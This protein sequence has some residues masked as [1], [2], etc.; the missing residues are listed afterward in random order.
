MAGCDFA[1]SSRSG[2]DL[3]NVAL[4]PGRNLIAPQWDDLTLVTGSG[5]LNNGIYT[6]VM[7]TAPNRVLVIQWLGSYFGSS[8]NS[9]QITF[10]IK[11]HETTNEIE[12][13]LQ[14]LT[15][16][17]DTQNNGASATVG[18]AG[19]TGTTV[20]QLYFN[21]VIS[22]IPQARSFKPYTSVPPSN[23]TA[24]TCGSG[25]IDIRNPANLIAGTQGDELTANVTLPFKFNFYGQC[26]TSGV[27]STN[28]FLRFSPSSRSGA[29][30]SNAALTAGMN[31]IAPLWDDLNSATSL[32]EP[33]NGIYAQTNGVAPN[34]QYIL[35][36]VT[37]Y[38][39]SSNNSDS[40]LF[41][42]ILFEQTNEIRIL[43]QDVTDGTDTQNG[44]SSATVGI[45]GPSGTS[46]VQ[47]SLNT[48]FSAPTCF[49]YIIPCATPTDIT[50]PANVG[51]VQ[52]GTLNPLTTLSGNL[53]SSDP[54][55]IRPANASC[56]LDSI[57]RPYYDV[58]P[59]VVLKPGTFTLSLN[60]GGMDFFALIY[61]GQFNACNPC[62]SLVYWDDDTDS[63]GATP[64]LDPTITFTASGLKTYYLV[65]TSYCSG[66][67]GA[68]TWTI[69]SSGGGKIIDGSF[70]IANATATHC[71]DYCIAYN[72]AYLI[73]CPGDFK[74]DRKFLLTD[75]CLGTVVDSCTQSI[76]IDDTTPPVLICPGDMVVSCP[77]TLP[78]LPATY[79]EFLAA[80]GSA[81]DECCL[82]TSTFRLIG[83][84]PNP[85]TCSQPSI[86]SYEI[87]DTC[88]NA[89]TCMFN[90]VVNDIT[91]PTA[92]CKDITVNL[93]PMGMGMFMASQLDN[94]SSDDCPGGLIFSMDHSGNVTYADT[95]AKIPVTLTVM[96]SCG[97]SATCISLVCVR[98]S[99][100]LE[101]I[102][103]NI[104]VY[105]DAMGMVSFTA[106]DI[107]GGCTPS[108]DCGGFDL[109]LLH[110]GTMTC[111]SLG[112][113][114]VDLE[115]FDDCSADT[116]T[117]LVTVL[118]TIKPMITCPASLTVSC[119]SMVPAQDTNS[120]VATDNCPGVRRSFV[121]DQISSQTCQNRYTLTRTYMA[122]DR[123]GNTATCSQTIT[124]NDI[125]VPVLATCPA[126]VTIQCVIDTGIPPIV[127]FT[128]NC[129]MGTRNAIFGSRRTVG[130][131]RDSLTLFRTWTARDTCGNVASCTQKITI[132]DNVRPSMNCPAPI[133][134]TCASSVPPP[135]TGSVV[136]ADAC[137]NSGIVVVHLK[138]STVNMTCP[139]KFTVYRF[140]RATDACGNT[141]SCSQII[142]VNDNVNPTALCKNITLNLDP[143]GNASITASQINNGSTD[144][145]SSQ[146]NLRLAASPSVFT[147]ANSGP[148]NVTLSVTDECG[149]VGTCVA[150][151]TVSDVTPPVFV[152]S[153]PT[154]TITLNAGPG[155]CEVSWD[156]PPFMA[157]DNCPAG[158]FF[159]SIN[160]V[161]NICRTNAAWQ[162]SGGAGA[163]G[164]LFD[165]VNT[166]GGQLNLQE[167][168]WFSFANEPQYLLSDSTRPICNLRQATASAWTLCASR[169]ATH[170]GFSGPKDTFNLITGTAY[171]TLK[172]CDPIIVDSTKI[173]C[174]TMAAG[175]TRGV[176]IHAPGQASAYLSI[177]G[178]CTTGIFGDAN[179]NTPVNGATYTG[180]L[181]TAPFVNSSFGFGN[182]NWIG[183]IGYALATSNRV[184][185]IQTCGAPYGP[186]CFFPIG[187]TTLCYEARDAG[188]NLATCTFDVCVNAYANPKRS[189]SCND[190][191]QVSL[192]EEC[193]A[194]VGADDVLEGGPYSCYDEYIVE[195][196]NWNT[197]Q[198]IDRRPTVPESR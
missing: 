39:G 80:G 1:G 13:L 67:T 131:C 66:M 146:A 162:I 33:S 130:T 127:T 77:G 14:D 171:D 68:Y 122:T 4:T 117:A 61:N 90:I 92:R 89:D 40:L 72:D 64:N 71:Y 46:F 145:C 187:C 23:Y 178:D 185:V 12:I 48:A 135:N 118:D 105:L 150:I 193:Y 196:R 47:T 174:L 112:V 179:V 56:I 176:Y 55:F 121:S 93:D 53:I 51:P 10:E 164:V 5:E 2:T 63:T 186:G 129:Q 9:D 144:N 85:P 100:F 116:C 188:G 159:G 96:D 99:G 108:S 166:S 25:F 147:C 195:I 91:P 170:A 113:R 31:L 37:S 189:L 190:D 49:S 152:P 109:R 107:D 76:N 36:W 27:V 151:V 57:N 3:S 160:R 157:M 6:Q 42:I 95:L 123:S 192:D 158:Q 184:R 87:K 197:G 194:T 52:C 169:V 173:G 168:G 153:C 78:A 128:D 198:L 22:P 124:V 60:S 143:S 34:R 139:N 183:H 19:P 156:A 70:G 142:T 50:C 79:E 7:G 111:D 133:T 44:G 102:C 126:D 81:T 84:V 103:K 74:I 21:Q 83:V 69:S 32:S 43:H 136:A 59:L 73:T 182:T 35:Q 175:E 134:V 86:V 94:G 141:N 177:F 88:G 98:K 62:S 154:K 161:G 191:V 104:T 29:D 172:R 115:A 148:V 149:N 97:N 180:G 120:V 181:F 167:V 54:S 110:S 106:D 82:A 17:A 140:Y 137:G 8:G 38:F 45:A 16:A 163:W 41:E 18:V 101:A 138:D 11:Y 26:I 132:F 114:M 165:L 119:A 65:T 155:E 20:T 125:T 58:I 30:L 24:S 28:G 15:D 75:I